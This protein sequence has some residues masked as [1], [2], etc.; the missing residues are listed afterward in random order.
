MKKPAVYL[1]M[2][3]G[4]AACTADPTG[5]PPRQLR[6]RY[7]GGGW[8]IG[9]GKADTSSTN[10]ALTTSSDTCAAERG[11]GWTIGSGFTQ[12]PD[13]CLAQ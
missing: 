5:S 12:P 13:P 10:T 11:G 7:D 4:T 1:L 9:S 6:P 3:L 8:K 2:L